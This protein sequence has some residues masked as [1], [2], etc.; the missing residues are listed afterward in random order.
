MNDAALTALAASLRALPGSHTV[1]VLPAGPDR[2]GGTLPERVAIFAKNGKLA[3]QVWH[4]VT[5]GAPT[6]PALLVCGPRER[7]LLPFVARCTSVPVRT[8][9]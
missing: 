5:L 2:A 7:A 1:E 8:S 9:Y 3:A 6:R 4:S